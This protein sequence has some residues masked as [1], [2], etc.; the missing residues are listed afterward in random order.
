MRPLF[1]ICA[2]FALLTAPFAAQVSLPRV[3]VPDVGGVL[4]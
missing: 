2:L 4:D 1:L 3:G